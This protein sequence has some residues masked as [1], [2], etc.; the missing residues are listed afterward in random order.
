MFQSKS[1]P[2]IG[3]KDKERFAIAIQTM[4]FEESG[5]VIQVFGIIKNKENVQA[6]KVKTIADARRFHV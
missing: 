5:G 4:A 3:M 2:T 6:A 1:L